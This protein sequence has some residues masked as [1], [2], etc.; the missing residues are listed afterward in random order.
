MLRQLEAAD[1]PHLD[2]ITPPRVE[3]ATGRF[4][5]EDFVEDAQRGVVRCPAG[6]ES[7]YRQR[8][9][10]KH[11]SV[12]RFSAETC[13]SCPLMKQCLK[14]APQKQF[15]RT[16]RKNDFQR[17]YDQAR[18]KATTAK[19]AAIRREHPAIER[20]LSELVRRHGS[21]RARYRSLVC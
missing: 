9:N 21:R 19:Y 14:Q 7:K 5:T 17:E 13:A 20:K 1:G 6:Q 18:H 16:V 10:T 2:V 15:G 11:T 3:P 12:Y 8:D 4:R